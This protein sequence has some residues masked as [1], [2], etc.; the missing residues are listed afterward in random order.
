MKRDKCIEEL[1][2]YRSDQIVVAVYHAAFDLMRIQP[3]PLNY[4]SIG[5][6]GLTT[7]HALG[8]AI[9]CP[10]K[11]V[12]VL[13][14]DGSL[15]MGLGSLVTIAEVAP[16]NFLYFVYQNGTYEANG[17]HPI[18]GRDTMNFAAIARGAGFQEVY[19][20]SDFQAYASALPTL[21]QLKG[22]VFVTMK[23]EPGEQSPK[24]WDVIHGAETRAR[25]RCELSASCPSD[26]GSGS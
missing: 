8:L 1:A 16:A 4:L 17:G 19:E 6:M 18:P 10:N 13:D 7:S 11:K 14:G 2:R 23:V 12:I 3:H 21:L 20:F 25:F 24:N 22:P 9:G 5:A 26:T 15:L